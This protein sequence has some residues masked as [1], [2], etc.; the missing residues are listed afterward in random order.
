MKWKILTGVL[1]FLFLQP[2]RAE[3]VSFVEKY[4]YN[5]GEADSKL[6]C[7]SISLLEVKRLLVERIGTY[8][9][10]RTTVA[11][12]HITRDEIVSFS[13]GI[14]KTEILEEAWD[15]QTYRLTARIEADP[16]SVVQMIDQLKKS[17]KRAENFQETNE[18][19]LNKIEELKL[20]L[21]KTQ[22]DFIKIT[23]DYRDSVQIIEAWNAFEN[24][25][26]SMRAGDRTEAI[27]ILTTATQENP[28]AI[29]YFQR[30]RAYQ[31]LNRF[32]EALSDY[33]TTINLDPSIANAYFHKGQALIRVGKKRKGL[34]H[35]RKAAELGSGNAR[36]WLML[37]GKM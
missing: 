10:S 2:Y 33:T 22:E 12:F 37:K 1:F 32:E 11:D 19:F 8:L 13:A 9:E 15:G 25:L 20:E 29:F 21:S 34:A 6:T 16:Q 27:A 30:G 28:K 35:I 3:A 36:R 7:R 23:H 17:G 31:R 26:Q 5:A 4:R 24:A 18:M 14:V